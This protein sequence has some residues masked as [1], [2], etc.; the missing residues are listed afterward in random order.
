MSAFR[1]SINSLSRVVRISARSIARPSPSFRAFSDSIT[2]SG[3]Q[4]TEGQGGFYSAG[5][6]R[7]Q[8]PESGTEARPEMLALAADVQRITSVMEELDTLQHLLDRETSENEGQVSGKSIELRGSIKKL[9][10][11]PEITECLNR[12]EVQGEPVWGL[13]SNER[14]LIRSARETVNNC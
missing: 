7:A 5:G 8:V 10:T 2:Y 14:D 3:G 12:L 6:A 9:M 4:A 1:V 11:N 13:S